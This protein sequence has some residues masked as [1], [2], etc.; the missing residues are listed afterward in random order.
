MPVPHICTVDADATCRCIYLRISHSSN[1]TY[2]YSI[3]VTLFFRWGLVVNKPFRFVFLDGHFLSR[4]PLWGR[5]GFFLKSIQLIN[6]RFQGKDIF[7]FLGRGIP[8]PFYLQG[9]ILFIRQAHE[10]GRLDVRT[11]LIIFLFTFGVG[12]ERGI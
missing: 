9:L 10:G 2:D 6:F 11:V 12:C 5:R 3:D 7:L 1:T 8:C 4:V